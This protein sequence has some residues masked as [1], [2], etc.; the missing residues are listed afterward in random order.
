[1]N[2]TRFHR[3]AEFIIVDLIKVLS[4]FELFAVKFEPWKFHSF[5]AFRILLN[6]GKRSV[7]LMFE[8]RISFGVTVFKLVFH[9]RD[10]LI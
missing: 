3:K 9:L 5:V 7:L 4:L 10:E 1:M 8:E 6:T 2:W